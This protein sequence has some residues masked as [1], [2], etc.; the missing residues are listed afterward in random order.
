MNDVLCIFLFGALRFHVNIQIL[1]GDKP[2]SGTLSNI[3]SLFAVP[4][5]IPYPPSAVDSSFQAGCHFSGANPLHL[6]V[7]VLGSGSNTNVLERFVV[8]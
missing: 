8:Y 1:L 5:T 2:C 4:A 7:T 6:V 3:C